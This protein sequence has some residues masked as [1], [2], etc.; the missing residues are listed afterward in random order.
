MSLSLFK[1]NSTVL[2]QGLIKILETEFSTLYKCFSDFTIVG[3]PS[4]FTMIKKLT[5][6]SDES[7]VKEKLNLAV[8]LG[9]IKNV[10]EFEKDLLNGNPNKIE[11]CNRIGEHLNQLDF[12]PVH[13]LTS[14]KSDTMWMGDALL[15]ARRNNKT[16]S[17]YISQSK[18]YQMESKII[19]SSNSISDLESYV[20]SLNLVPSTLMHHASLHGKNFTKLTTLEAISLMTNASTDHLHFLMCMS[21]SVYPKE[22]VLAFQKVK[23]EDI[24]S[25]QQ[26]SDNR[27]TVDSVI[28]ASGK[29]IEM[30]SRMTFKMA[31]KKL[32]KDKIP[33][34]SM[35]K[36]STEI[37]EVSEKFFYAWFDIDEKSKKYMEDLKIKDLH[38][39]LRNYIKLENMMAFQIRGGADINVVTGNRGPFTKDTYFKSIDYLMGMELSTLVKHLASPNSFDVKHDSFE[40]FL[41]ESLGQGKGWWHSKFNP[42]TLIQFKLNTLSDLGI[43]LSSRQS[44]NDLDKQI[45]NQKG[46]QSM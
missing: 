36:I 41:T 16:F 12:P 40:S 17:P 1:A 31:G 24:F 25:Q 38:F 33:S 3:V 21:Q 46:D 43:S 13:I 29:K 22:V 11:L 34:Y 8:A 2:R 7:Y 10:T 9:L 45:K 44:L 14:Y 37:T 42:V 28:M 23:I 26:I 20:K 5:D 30:Q 27:E 6:I 15:M 18:F 39:L 4:L 35:M 19:A 32:G